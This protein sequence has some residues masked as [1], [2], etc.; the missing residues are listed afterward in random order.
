[1]LSAVCAVSATNSIEASFLSPPE[2]AKPWVY[3]FWLNGNITKE[4]ITADLEAMKRVGIGGVLIMEV[5]QGVPSGPI[6]FMSGAWRELFQYMVA[7]ADR[8]GLEVNMNNDAGWNG[9]GGPWIKPEESMQKVV[10]SETEL[11]GPQHFEGTL[12]QPETIAAYYKDIVV[13][14]FPACGDYRIDDINI[15]ACYQAGYMAPKV[16]TSDVSPDMKI[17][18]SRLLDLSSY[19]N[20]DGQL[21]WDVPQGKWTILRFGHTSTGAEN[22]PAPKSGRGLE[23]D[24]L[25]REGIEANFNGMMSKLIVDVGELAGKTLVTTHIDSWEN[26]AQN[27]T[28]KMRE[29]FKARRGYDPLPYLPVI[30]G[31]VVD[32]LE[33]SERFLRDWRQT[34]SDLVVENYAGHLQELAAAHGMRLSIEA[35]GGPCDNAPYAGRCDEPMGEFWIGGGGFSSLKDMSSAAHTYGKNIIGA[36]AFTAADHEK[37][38][39][40]PA[41]IKALGDRAFCDGINRFVFH[42]YALQPWLNRS[43]GMTMGPWGIH[44]ERTQTWWEQTKPWHEYLARCQFMLRRGLF[45]A[46]IVYLQPESAPKGFM[47]HKRK[48]YDF[49]EC[50]AEVV[51]KRMTVKDGY[52]V[53]P[54]GMKYKML[55]LPDVP[56]M[57]PE[58]LQKV[59]TLIEAGA[60]VMGRPPQKSPS[61][62][63]YPE[64]DH[65]VQQ[66]AAEIWGDCDGVQCTEYHL[67]KGR[68]V[69][70][71]PPE[72]F[73][74]KEG[75]SPDFMAHERLNFIHRV[76]DE[77]DIYFVANPQRHTV[78]TTCTFR[79][80]DSLPELWWPETGKIEDAVMYL[81]REDVTSVLLT[82]EPSSSVFVVFGKKTSSAD[83]IINVTR[84]GEKLLSVTDPIE[85]VVITKAIYGIQEEPSNCRD[86]RDKVQQRIQAGE[87]EIRVSSMA[88]GDDPAPGIIKTLRVDYSIGD[89]NFSVSGKDPNTIHI[90]NDA[91]TATIEKAT[92][93]VPGDPERT[94]DVREKLQQLVDS[95]ESWFQVARMAQGDDPAFMVVK[96]LHADY[97][98]DGKHYSISGTDP[99]ILYLA[100]HP[101]MNYEPNP[102]LFLQD[103]QYCLQVWQ[104]GSYQIETASG[105]SQ[106]KNINELPEPK[107]HLGPWEVRFPQGSGAPDSV[108]MD[109]LIPLNEHPDPGV[110]YFSGTATYSTTIHVNK[111]QL[112]KNHTL[113]LDLG[114]V[115]VMAEVLVNGNAIAMLWKSPYRCLLS[116]F[117]KEGDNTLEIKVTNLWVNRLIGD[118]QLPEDSDRYPAG[119][120]KEW[121]EWLTA[122]QPSPTGRFAFTTWNLWK[123]EDALPPSG[124]IGPVKLRT[125]LDIHIGKK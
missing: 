4:G 43:P 34:I 6:G 13:Y 94:R 105:K 123:K 69:W 122:G 32:S 30:T 82:L 45:A 65:Q 116:G 114:E 104:P 47:G 28:A 17:S 16:I 78:T 23:C 120:L 80:T 93:G 92:Y 125:A 70:P 24:K 25:S 108:R 42:R 85:P 107:E 52:I 110:H 9:S 7:E 86:V 75:L 5:D 118:E 113:W 21:S 12:Q 63:N 50:S 27:W 119:N 54:D 20:A 51:L 90:T 98:I 14:A 15:K 106:T 66:L 67:G 11:E 49:D 19:M 111:S 22:A 55:V 102:Q 33:I 79:V 99:E 36:E 76:D 38:Q 124:L 115:Q 100:P 57:T 35:Y 56:A 2:D 95:G 96:T 59:K 121:P 73:L 41:S 89:R 68:I 109:K 29:E 44:Y 74:Q 58:L 37:W 77:Q 88:E 97:T 8:L 40:H 61:L 83:P 53:L 1:M 117:V 18:P 26:G 91:I 60:T 48:G 112:E 46:D 62:T 72:K 84:D 64:C 39:E 101:A 31:R 10:F 87:R 103:N 3:W 71:V 81:I